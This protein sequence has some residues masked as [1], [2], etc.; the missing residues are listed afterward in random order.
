MRDLSGK[1]RSVT[2]PNGNPSFTVYYGSERD[3]RVKQ[4][5]DAL[6][7]TTQFDY[8][9]NGNVV[10]VTDP[11][12]R[13]T[14]TCYDELNRPTRVMGPEYNDGT[15]LGRPETRTTYDPLGRVI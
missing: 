3:G 1:V 10:K 11:L 8:D 6:G 5:I 2:D 7:R 4:R 15:G 13:T 12:G 14:L 9:P